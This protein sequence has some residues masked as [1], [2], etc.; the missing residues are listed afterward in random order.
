M[1]FIIVFQV[2]HTLKCISTEI[3]T[4]YQHDTIWMN[5]KLIITDLNF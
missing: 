4:T 1:N 5:E 3:H 2:G